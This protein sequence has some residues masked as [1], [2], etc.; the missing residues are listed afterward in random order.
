MWVG[1]SKWW[2]K[3]F[4]ISTTPVSNISQTIYFDKKVLLDKG[5][6]PQITDDCFCL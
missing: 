1:S 4:G 2:Y 3:K 5:L 6:E